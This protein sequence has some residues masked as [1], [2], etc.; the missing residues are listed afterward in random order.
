MNYVEGDTLNIAGG[1]KEIDPALSL[2]LDYRRGE[3]E[4]KRENRHVMYVKPGELDNR[5]LVTLR[6]NDLTRR[7]LMDYILELERSED[8][9]ERRKAREYSNKIQSMTL[10]NYD[11]IVGIP[12]FSC[13]H[14][15]KGV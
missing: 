10:D 12:H 1:V 8:E 7:R 13:G 3:F 2:S 9:A 6:K 15:D 4:I 5:V 11:R 14:W